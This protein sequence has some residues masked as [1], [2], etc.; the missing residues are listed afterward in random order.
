MW[1][2]A[3]K[4]NITYSAES[5]VNK[6]GS[7]PS[8]ML[9][10]ERLPHI[11]GQCYTEIA[12]NAGGCSAPAAVLCCA[13]LPGPVTARTWG[14]SSGRS[15]IPK[16]WL[17]GQLPQNPCWASETCSTAGEPSHSGND[18]NINHR[19]YSRCTARNVL[20][21]VSSFSPSVR[22]VNQFRQ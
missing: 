5:E 12:T 14:Y 19:E 9:W 7:P 16:R 3:F 2:P 8:P 17:H 15:G 22:A 11:N 18:V 10:S 1:K 13:A 4:I 20:A 21:T 6:D